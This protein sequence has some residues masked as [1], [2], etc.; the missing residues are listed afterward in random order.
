MLVKA[1]IT[2]CNRIHYKWL[3]QK[4]NTT[5][6]NNNNNNEIINLALFAYVVDATAVYVQIKPYVE[7]WN[8]SFC[9]SLSRFSV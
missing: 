8:N 3:L 4:N 1:E 9:L 7:T 5:T 6:N 2:I